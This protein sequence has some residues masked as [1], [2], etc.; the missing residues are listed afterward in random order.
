[1]SRG[2][3]PQGIRVEVVRVA[4]LEAG[5][6]VFLDGFWWWVWEVDVD[7]ELQ[8][9]ASMAVRCSWVDKGEEHAP[10]EREKTFYMEPGTRLLAALP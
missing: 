10:P 4:A 6:E 7:H 5:R 8:T 2:T 9:L 3:G 1:M